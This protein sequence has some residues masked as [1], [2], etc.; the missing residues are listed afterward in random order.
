MNKNMEPGHIQPLKDFQMSSDQS[1]SER[2]N[3]EDRGPNEDGEH[4][5]LLDRPL[6]RDPERAH[7]ESSRMSQFKLNIRLIWI[8]LKN[9]EIYRSLLFFIITGF[10]LPNFEDVQYY[11]LLNDCNISQD[12]YDQLNMC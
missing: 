1:F 7:H 9:K 2:Q 11:F 4:H 8:A 5:Q 12:D 10:I 3:S 6:D